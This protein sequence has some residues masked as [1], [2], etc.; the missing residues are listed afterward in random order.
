MLDRTKIADGVGM[1]CRERQTGETARGIAGMNYQT[2]E[3][4]RKNAVS[5]RCSRSQDGVRTGTGRLRAGSARAPADV[6]QGRQCVT[7]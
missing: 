5:L 3:G 2:R 6:R 1:R 7:L 4:P